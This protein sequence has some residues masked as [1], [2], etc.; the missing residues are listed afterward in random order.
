MDAAMA[1]AGWTEWP[2]PAKLNLFLRIVGRRADGYHA[3]QTAF[4]LLEW[5]DRVR[6]RM[7]ADGIIRRAGLDD[8]VDDYGVKEFDD[9]T[10]R[11]ARLLQTESGSTLGCDIAVKKRIPLGGGFG[12][13]SS[14]AATT[15]VAL[16]WLWGIHLGVDRLAALG[17]KLGADVPV[18]VY[19]HNAWAEGV[20]EQLTPLAL[21]PRWYLIVDP[22]VHVPTAELFQV[23]GLTRDAAPATMRGFM[24]DSAFGNAFEPVLRQREPEIVAALEALAQFGKACVTG[25]GSGCFVAFDAPE[26]AESA[27]AALPKRWKGWIATGASRSPLLDR[28]EQL[29]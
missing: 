10:I 19:G 4:Q 17:L 28:L 20:G 27:L 25:S 11:A 14:D 29:H 6:L 3:L 26:H 7:R 18:F 21:P 13:G 9:L 23:P 12:G 5:G 24:F 2:A 16:D 8:S 1:A 22:G 15:L